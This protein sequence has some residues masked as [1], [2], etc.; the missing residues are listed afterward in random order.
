MLYHSCSLDLE[1]TTV[2]LFRFFC[3]SVSLNS[4]SV[5]G[6]P[7]V[8]GSIFVGFAA[9]VD[10]SDDIPDGGGLVYSHSWTLLGNQTLAVVVVALY[11]LIMTV[12]ILKIMSLFGSSDSHYLQGSA[13]G[14]GESLLPS[15]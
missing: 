10:F 14:L 3:F 5:H 4:S 12:M 1:T 11:T 13:T 9:N 6:M 2:G 7:G 15:P 8:I